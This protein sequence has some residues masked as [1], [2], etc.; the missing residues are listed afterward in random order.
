MLSVVADYPS[1]CHR[2]NV[3][4]Q[5]KLGFAKIAKTTLIVMKIQTN[6]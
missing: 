2:D 6:R 4:G 5:H 1:K 3:D